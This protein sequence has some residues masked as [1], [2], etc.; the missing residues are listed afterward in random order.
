MHI[1]LIASQIPDHI[2]M[3]VETVMND[4]TVGA[5]AQ[6]SARALQTVRDDAAKAVTVFV[7][8]TGPE[9]GKKALTTVSVVKKSVK[10]VGSELMT[11]II[12]P[13][14]T[15]LVNETP[16]LTKKVKTASSNFMSDVIMP[17]GDLFIDNLPTYNETT[18]SIDRHAK[19]AV[20][21]VQAVCRELGTYFPQ[22][23]AKKD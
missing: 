14:V 9:Y 23:V 2:N 6:A 16:K 7:S 5:V 15:L 10:K 11:D 22:K 18:T 3:A 1:Q 20:E 17:A 19:A 8:K 13:S 4:K 21:N 12:Y